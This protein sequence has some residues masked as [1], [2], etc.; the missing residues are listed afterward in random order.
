MGRPLHPLS[1]ADGL[2]ASHPPSHIGW[3]EGEEEAGS[4][5]SADTWRN[6]KW[7]GKGGW[8]VL[9]RV[10]GIHCVHYIKQKACTARFATGAI[11]EIPDYKLNQVAPATQAGLYRRGP[12]Y[13]T[14]SMDQIQS[15]LWR[16]GGSCP[17]KVFYLYFLPSL[18]DW[19]SELRDYDQMW[20]LHWSGVWRRF[21]RHS[22]IT[23]T[24]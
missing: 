4:S 16:G 12:L 20:P 8:I 24:A 23:V 9:R 17:Q 13:L 2:P 22:I 3:K 7:S 6:Y 10:A 19:G 5:A 15:S 1:A 11:W 21:L 14:Y 18:K